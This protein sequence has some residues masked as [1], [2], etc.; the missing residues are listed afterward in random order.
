MAMPFSKIVASLH[1]AIRDARQAQTANPTM[2][3]PG[4]KV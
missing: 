2:A 3:T 1:V 4:A